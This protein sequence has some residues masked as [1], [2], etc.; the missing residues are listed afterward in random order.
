MA[1]LAVVV[2]A[3]RSA[4][5]LR[6][7]LEGILADPAAAVV[8][9]DNSGDPATARLCA[10]PDLAG[11]VSYLDPGVNLGYA[12]AANLGLS[13]RGDARTVAIVNPDVRLTRALTDLLR[14]A[15]PAGRDV[16][17]GRLV[18][19]AHPDAV[20]ARPATT[21]GRELAKAVRGS[22]AYRLPGLGAPDGSVHT[23]AQLDGA[24]L[25]LGA[26]RWA[27]LGGFDERFELYYEDVDLCAR[28][29]G[30]C[31]LVNTVWGEHIGGH[32]FRRSAGTAFAALRISRV[33][34]ARRW[35]RPRR[36]AALA[37]LVITLAE[38]AARSLTRC[39]EGQSVRNRTLGLTLAELRRPG[40]QWVLRPRSTMKEQ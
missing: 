3:Y 8:V 22:R 2:V 31:R 13:R 38:Y 33:R 34:Y 14:T 20:N 32:S 27:E 15:R 17:A 18:S 12:R 37:V 29:E 28:A 24:L 6:P 11:R 25:V 7:C 4:E 9:V 36:L 1:E 30:S 26:E 21:P 39:P 19:P 16:T 10:A 35:W 40:S 23:V 5:T